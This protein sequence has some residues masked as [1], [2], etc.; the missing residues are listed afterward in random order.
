MGDNLVAN[1]LSRGCRSVT[2]PGFPDAPWDI[3]ID[4]G[5]SL[6]VLDVLALG[7]D[8]ITEP[9]TAGAA[10]Q[11]A[12][13]EVSRALAADIESLAVAFRS[14]ENAVVLGPHDFRKVRIEF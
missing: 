5:E 11:F 12:D 6:V 14:E 8:A 9:D 7:H 3:D 4:L 2:S 10:L 1:G 13:F